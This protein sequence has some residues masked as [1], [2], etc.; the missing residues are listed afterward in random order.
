MKSVIRTVGLFV[1][2]FLAGC[3]GGGGGV[4]GGTGLSVTYRTNWASSTGSQVVTLESGGRAIIGTRVLN[5]AS[6]QTEAIF[7][8]LSPG[9]YRVIARHHAGSDGNG[10]L[11]GDLETPLNVTT[12]LTA[13]T[14]TTGTAIEVRV[15]PS[16]LSLTVGGSRILSAYARTNSGATLFTPPNGFGWTVTGAAAS[17]SNSGL[18]TG[19]QVGQSTINVR[20]FPSN[21]VAPVNVSVTNAVAPRT[22]WTILVYMNAASDLHPFSVLNVNQMESIA[23][24]ADVRFVLQWKQTRDIYPN[25]SFDGTRRM[26]VK[27]DTTQSIASELIQDMGTQVD[28]GDKATLSQFINWGKTNYPADR[29]GIVM[30]SHGNGWRRGER[31]SRAASYDDQTGNAIQIWELADAIGQ[32]QFEFLAWDMSLMQMTEVAYEVK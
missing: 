6:G 20:H 12:N 22:K 7:T 29:Y 3:G 25:S 30:W 32:D 27:P 4:G 11:L 18:A 23:Q 19:L 28:M 10:L 17:I 8:D 9:V 24:N 14:V 2:L 15:D 5:Q 13:N 26:L 1:G 31:P 16:S 21:L